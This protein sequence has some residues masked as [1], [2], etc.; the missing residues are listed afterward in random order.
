MKQIGILFG[1]LLFL[2]CISVKKKIIDQSTIKF[3]GKN[4]SISDYIEVKGLYYN[5]KSQYNTVALFYEDGTFVNLA[6]KTE[7][8]DNKEHID[9][10]FEYAAHMNHDGQVHLIGER[11]VYTIK[12]DTIIVHVYY[13]GS[14]LVSWS[15]D[16]VRYKIIDSRTIERVYTKCLSRADENYYKE[17][18]KSP[19]IKDKP[20]HF[21]SV[22]SLPSSNSSLKEN[23]WIWRNEA[24]WKE[25]IRRIKR[26]R[27]K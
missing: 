7:I 5:Y 21:R 19:W 11:G 18:K 13:P 22:D 12:N 9:N 15:L 4:T 1:L 6:I 24:D 16:E 27:S 23:K 10:I 8:D 14:L 26:E 20:I 3:E 25:Y 17:S 2:S